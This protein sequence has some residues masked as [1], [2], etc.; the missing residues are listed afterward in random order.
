MSTPHTDSKNEG[1]KVRTGRNLAAAAQWAGRY[2]QLYIPL[3][4]QEQPGC[5]RLP[6]A[7]SF[8]SNPS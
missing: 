6:G 5:P 1:E 4:C 3:P 8:L 2:H 7:V